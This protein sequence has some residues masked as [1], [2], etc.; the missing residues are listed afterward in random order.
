VQSHQLL[1]E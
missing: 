1:A